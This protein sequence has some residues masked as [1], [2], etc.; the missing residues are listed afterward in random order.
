[1]C[2]VLI[3]DPDRGL[4]ARYRRWLELWGFEVETAGSGLECLDRLREFRPDVLVLEPELPWGWGDGVLALLREDQT[5]PRPPVVVVTYKVRDDRLGADR[6]LV[7]AVC[8]KPLEPGR[9]VEVVQEVA[10]PDAFRPAATW[11]NESAVV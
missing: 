6:A 10:P 3:A 4:T 1:M 7:R 8:L 2:R 9:L 11:F 5:L